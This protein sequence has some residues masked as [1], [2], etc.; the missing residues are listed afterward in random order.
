MMLMLMDG[1][2]D[3]DHTNHRPRL[4]EPCLVGDNRVLARPIPDEHLFQSPSSG[5][6]TVDTAASETAFKESVTLILD[7]LCS[8]SFE[9]LM[10]RIC[11]NNPETL[12]MLIT[13]SPSWNDFIVERQNRFSC[14]YITVKV[15]HPGHRTAVAAVPG[16][17]LEDDLSTWVFGFGD[18]NKT[19]HRVLGLEPSSSP[20]SDSL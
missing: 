11:H 18:L 5:T 6:M 20:G 8:A 9:R 12:T 10:M 13:E 7:W 1:P 19:I 15:S 16:A 3:F 14:G 2:F 17:T 4:T